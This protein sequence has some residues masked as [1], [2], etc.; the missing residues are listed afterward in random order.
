MLSTLIW[1]IPLWLWLIFIFFGLYF[2]FTLTIFAMTPAM[3]WF[4]AKMRKVPVQIVQF[5]DKFANLYAPDSADMLI[6][7]KFG[8][9]IPDADSV[10]RTPKGDIVICSDT[11]GVTLPPKLLMTL[12][13]LREDLGITTYD[14]LEILKNLIEMK[15]ALNNGEELTKQQQEL[16]KKLDLT[17][18]DLKNMDLKEE[19]ILRLYEPVPIYYVF[20]F[21]K[22]NLDA[23]VTKSKIEQEIALRTAKE[24]KLLSFE[25]VLLF[26]MLLLGAAVAY[27]LIKSVGG[28]GGS[29]T[30]VIKYVPT[31]VKNTT[32]VI[33]A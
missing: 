30:Q 13:A 5:R 19:V 20:D 33:P 6:N 31:A 32:Q 25:N 8:A 24:R 27:V 3:T 17:V 16:L 7:G 1:G 29:A 14:E 12:R 15:K 2:I 18:N 9:Y 10:I 21:F 22:K 4:K 11:F 28:G 23:A 26:V